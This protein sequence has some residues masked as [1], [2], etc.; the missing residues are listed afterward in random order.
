MGSDL[1][2]GNAVLIAAFRDALLHQGFLIVLVFAVLGLA[3]VSIREIRRPL[4]PRMTG[5]PDAGRRS[6][7][8]PRQAAAAPSASRAGP[9]AA[10][11]RPQALRRHPRRARAALA[12]VLRIGFGLLWV[13]DGL[14]QAQP[15]MVGLATQVIKPESAGSP[16]WV[17]SIVDW[18]TASWTFHP[19]QAAA[20][21]VWIQLGIGVW[22][23][24]VRRGRWSQAAGLA[25]VAWGLVVWASGEAVGNMLAP[26][27]SF[28]TGEPWRGPA[29]RGGLLRADRAA[30]PGL[31]VGPARPLAAGLP[32]C[33]WSAWPWQA[34]R[35]AALRQIA[36][37]ARLSNPT[38]M[39]SRSSSSRAIP[40]TSW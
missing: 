30:R 21:A 36:T 24:A 11:R 2:N 14:L 33:S 28:L 38:A 3:L 25:G 32:G 34:R 40:R 35:S 6:T 13:I 9:K 7:P 1:G 22:M 5:G 10:D 31:G 8:S 39:L 19:V 4:P 29:V 18:G 20:A 12:A 16:A 37:M 15:A 23:L 17:R 26:G 27:Q